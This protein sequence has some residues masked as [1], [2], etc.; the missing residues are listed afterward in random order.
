MSLEFLSLETIQEIAHRFGYLAV[1]L[2]I[3]FENL[4]IPL[5]GETVT[6]VGGFLAGSGELNYWILLVDAILGAVLG[7][8]CGYWIGRLGGWS[9]LVSIGSFFRIKEEQL[10]ELKDK[11]TENAS[12][13]V[14]FGRFVALLRIFAS[15]MAGIVEMPF[16]KFLGFNVAGATVWASVMVSLA[17]F[18]GRIVSLEQLVTWAAQFAFVALLIAIAVIVIPIWL[19]SRKTAQ[20]EQPE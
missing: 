6:I 3:L 10:V 4:G 16:W 17:F 13:A 18:V 7:G 20:P 9:M 2:G 14:F 5:P 15:P 1:F 19:E 11:F 8:I 12:K